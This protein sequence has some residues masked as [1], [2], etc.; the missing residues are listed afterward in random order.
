MGATILGRQHRQSGPRVIYP[1]FQAP[2]IKIGDQVLFYGNCRR[3]NP[4][5][6]EVVE[7]LK[8]PIGNPLRMISIMLP[9]GERRDS[10]M[11]VDDPWCDDQRK[12]PNGSWDF[13]PEPAYVT[14]LRSEVAELRNRLQQ[15][16]DHLL[17]TDAAPKSS[18]GKRRGLREKRRA[19]RQTA[20]PVPQTTPE[21]ET[22]E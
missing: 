14:A 7:A 5:P 9:S 8:D 19:G 20:A 12:K 10:V 4:T 6:G 22:K 18:F 11:H 13:R 1:P 15:I 3:A 17:N 16:E 2:E 21:N